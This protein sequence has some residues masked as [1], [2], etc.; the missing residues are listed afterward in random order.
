MPLCRRNRGYSHWN[1]NSDSIIS[2]KLF[3]NIPRL[4]ES[5]EQAERCVIQWNAI[6]NGRVK[7]YQTH[8]GEWDDYLDVKPD[9]RKKE[10]LEIVK[11][12]IIK[13]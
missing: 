4:L 13:A 7:G 11:I 12:R 3:T 1:P 2:S 8:D 9:N 5:K 10:D 6:P